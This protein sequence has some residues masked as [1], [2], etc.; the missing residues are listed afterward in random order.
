MPLYESAQAALM[1]YHRLNILKKKKKC[2]FSQFGK[3]QVQDQGAKG[4][5]SGGPVFSLCCRHSY[6]PST[7][8]PV[9]LP[10][11]SKTPIL[12]DEVPT[13]ILYLTL[14]ISLKAISPNTIPLGVKTST[15]ENRD[16]I[17]QS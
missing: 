3:L 12:L 15:Y 8:P 13:L 16:I 9:S 4:L 1:E 17:T 2:I 6:P 11:L 10:L 7:C 14:I 5:V